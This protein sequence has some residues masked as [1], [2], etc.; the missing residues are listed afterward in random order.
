VEAP[1]RLRKLR[2]IR[3]AFVRDKPIALSRT[4]PDLLPAFRPHVVSSGRVH[5]TAGP[6]V[7][8]SRLTVEEEIPSTSEVSSIV[9]PAKNLS[10]TIGFVEIHLG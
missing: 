7:I 5:G 8:Q 6:A 3:A 1:R 9:S 4:I 10:S 2:Q